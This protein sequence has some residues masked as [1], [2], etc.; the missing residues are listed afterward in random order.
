MEVSIQRKLH[1][2][3]FGQISYTLARSEF[4]DGSGA[5]R[6]SSWDRRHVASVNLGWKLPKSWDIGG[7][8]GYASGS[9]Y[10][11]Y[12]LATSSLIDVYDALGEGVLD[13]TQLN[14]VRIASGYQLDIRID[15]RWYFK[16]WSMNLYFDV[17]N[18][19][20]AVVAREPDLLLQ[21]DPNG[22]ALIDPNDP[23]RYLLKSV[24]E[25]DGFLQPSIGL[26]LDF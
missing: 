25:E 26:I 20:N 10:T 3:L 4:T 8:I 9:P 21:L 18:A 1:K 14:A 16:S 13:Y 11:P 22:N 15:K 12:D 24:A 6:P 7:R 17:R 2:R 5:Y 19:T 23:S